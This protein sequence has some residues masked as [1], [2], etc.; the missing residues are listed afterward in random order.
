MKNIEFVIQTVG[1]VNQHR[2]GRKYAQQQVANKQT[3]Q[4]YCR[5]SNVLK[6]VIEMIT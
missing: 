2:R 5:H 3:H 6:P 4:A 1:R